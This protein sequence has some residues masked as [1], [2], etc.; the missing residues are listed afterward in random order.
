MA[1]VYS[2]GYL[3]LTG[4]RSANGNGGPFFKSHD[5]AVPEIKSLGVKYCVFFRQ[6]PDHQIEFENQS[7]ET[8]QPLL[9]R[10]WVTRNACYQCAFCISVDMS[11]FSSAKRA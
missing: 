10:A 6:R 1:S 5:V 4:T 11:S 3:T 7:T 8:F 9:T 2:N